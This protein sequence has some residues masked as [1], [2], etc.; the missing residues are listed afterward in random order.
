MGGEGVVQPTAFSHKV[1]LIESQAELP[2]ENFQTH[3]YSD[4]VFSFVTLP[5]LDFDLKSPKPAVV[6]QDAP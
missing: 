3:Q 5:R 1:V 6:K 4:Y 2:R